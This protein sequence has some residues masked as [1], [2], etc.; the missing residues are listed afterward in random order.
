MAREKSAMWPKNSQAAGS[1]N[2]CHRW[3]VT[4]KQLVVLC[5]TQIDYYFIFPSLQGGNFWEINNAKKPAG[6]QNA[7]CGVK[8]VPGPS[9]VA[10]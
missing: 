10:I 8:K 4:P 3:H 6:L 9:I 2:E 1:Q 7:H 5:H